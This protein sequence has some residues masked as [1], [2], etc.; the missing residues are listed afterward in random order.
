MGWDGIK[1]AGLVGPLHAEHWA[2]RLDKVARLA[3]A[4]PFLDS[5]ITGGRLQ[6]KRPPAAVCSFEADQKS[7]ERHR[8]GWD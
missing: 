2:N 1:A 5:S 4:I 3:D 6:L 7:G 8:M